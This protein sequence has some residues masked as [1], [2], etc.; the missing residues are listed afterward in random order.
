MSDMHMHSPL[1]AH[2]T[3]TLLSPV[4]HY[5]PA[6]NQLNPDVCVAPPS[7]KCISRSFV[8]I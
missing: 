5:L 3:H 1:I 8:L 2:N 6:L 4:Y 7:S